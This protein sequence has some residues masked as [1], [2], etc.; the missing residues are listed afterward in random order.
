MLDAFGLQKYLE[1]ISAESCQLLLNEHKPHIV[2]GYESLL[3][4]SYLSAEKFPSF[5]VIR[6]DRCDGSG[7]VFLAFDSNLPIV[8][9]PELDADAEMIWAR[10]HG[11][12]SKPVTAVYICSLYRIPNSNTGTILQLQQ[13]LQKLNNSQATIILAGDFNIPGKMA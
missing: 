4:N 3:D 13:S 11:K 9:M 6:K 7:G 5:A 10:F 8:E 2:I 1:F 12:G